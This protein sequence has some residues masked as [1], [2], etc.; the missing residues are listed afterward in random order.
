MK[1]PQKTSNWLKPRLRLWSI[2]KEAGY[3]PWRK[4]RKAKKQR[5]GVYIGTRE[6]I[7]FVNDDAKRTFSHLLLR[8]GYMIRDYVLGND[9]ERYLAPFTALLVF[10]SVFTLIV[11]VVRPGTNKDS[12]FDSL[13]RGFSDATT[14]VH[15]STEKAR[16]ELDFNGDTLSV[17]SSKLQSIATTLKDALLLTRLDLYPEAAD[18]PWKESLAAVE[19]DLRSKGIPL[20]LGN[21]LLMWMAMAIVLRKY[22]VS[23][24]GA[25]ATSAYVL[26]QFCIFMFL[27]LI[28]SF[29]HSSD[30]G[31]LLMGVLLFIDYRQ[32]LKVGNR[33]ALG[34]T[35]KT[36]LF[37]LIAMILFYVLIGVAIVLFALSK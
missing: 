19:G 32:M 17:N 34:L 11:A 20:F 5:K 18:T 36:G 31:L 3:N 30:L 25:A 37:Y 9:H 35:V 2:Y 15:D 28:L 12:M 22:K 23:F 24:S 13:I 33:K 21:F 4:P 29:G 8:P 14:V 10:Y 26:C 27:A 7:P 6:A 1:L 16:L